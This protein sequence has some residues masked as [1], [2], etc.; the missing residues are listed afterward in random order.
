MSDHTQTSPCT[1]E[2]RLARM[3][4]ILEER[5]PP[6]FKVRFDRVERA[7]KTAARVSWSAV[8]GLLAAFGAY[9]WDRLSGRAH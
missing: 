6:N 8:G 2:H 4:T 5:L 7:H 1:C 3:E 9:V